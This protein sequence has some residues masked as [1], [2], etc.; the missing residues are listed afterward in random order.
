VQLITSDDHSGL[1]AARLA[2]FGGLSWQRCQFH[3]DQNA[4]TYV[5]RRAMLSEV[6]ADIRAILMLQIALRQKPSSKKLS[7]NTLVPL[8]NWLLGWKRTSQKG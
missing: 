4:S 2:V 7:R 5:P 1:K 3:L 8:Q 6:T